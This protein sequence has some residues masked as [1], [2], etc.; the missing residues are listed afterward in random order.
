MKMILQV[1]TGFHRES[2]DPPEEVIRKIAEF[3]SRMDVDKVIIGWSTDPSV[4]RKVGEY[5]HRC[6]IKMLLWLPVFS[7]IPKNIQ[8]DPAKD[9]FGNP[10]PA[11]A[12]EEDIGSFHFVCPSSRRNIQI[13][14][15]RYEKYFSSCGFDGVFLDRIRTQSFVSGVSGV[16][17]CACEHCRDA[18][19]RKGVDVD[20]VRALY[21]SR[22][23]HFFDLSSWPLNG[24]F[25]LKH[26][27]AQRFFEA[28]EEII[29]DSVCEIAGV[30]RSKGL[31]IG[32]DLFA[33]VVSRL[34]GQ[35]YSLITK[36]ADFIKPMLYRRTEAPAGVGYELSLFDKAAPNAC[37]KIRPEMDAAF[38]HAQLEAM[39]NLPCEKYPGIEINYDKEIVRTDAGYIKESLDAVKAHGF[40]GAALCWNIMKAPHEH[41]IYQI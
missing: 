34:L 26:P 6:G 41:I 30:F 7:G 40:E 1:F 33:P 39:E 2:N 9:V 20:E 32:L 36:N 38:L 19:L 3:S 8:P 23:D 35:N 21:E 4:Y 29:A 27:L 13:A 12:L 17:S 5:L 31:L 18:F 24:A 28:K 37:G 11:P 15:D 16:L 25:V 10:V 14:T 22:K